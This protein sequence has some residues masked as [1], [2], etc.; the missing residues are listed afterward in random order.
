MPP[1]AAR[2]Y[3]EHAPF[4]RGCLRRF[5]VAADGLDDAAQDVFVV[6]VR[7]L[8]DL[9]RER[10]ARQWLWGITRRVAWSHLRK[11]RRARE[12][13]T[14]ARPVEAPRWEDRALVR[15]M[16]DR[17]DEPQREAFVLHDVLGH[18]AREIAERCEL[19]L[20]T[21][22][23]RIR[24]ARSRLR[25]E[26]PG[27]V[28]R[29]LAWVP[30]WS[31]G[32]LRLSSAAGANVVLGLVLITVP[33]EPQSAASSSAPRLA[34]QVSEPASSSTVVVD[35]SPPLPGPIA[36]RE[37]VETVEGRVEEGP[38]AVA[39]QATPPARERQ[40]ARRRAVPE[41][42]VVE[43]SGSDAWVFPDHDVESRDTGPRSY[44]ELYGR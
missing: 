34:A 33:A 28:A 43:A 1:D 9:D 21:V 2:L 3:T 18:S 40:R 35:A 19:P 17:L 27:L 7:R 14:V 11:A 32:T 30:G 38:V 8:S 23:W 37:G 36:V 22:Q 25:A 24:S 13:M 10:G 16:L 15:R 5:G 12:R 6:L 42:P 20:S 39:R 26:K 41:A 31:A 4:V 44:R 29:C